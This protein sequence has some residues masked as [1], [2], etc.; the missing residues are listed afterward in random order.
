[1]KL[2]EV[3]LLDYRRYFVE[4][5]GFDDAA[6]KVVKYIEFAPFNGILNEDGDLINEEG[7]EIEVLEVRVVSDF[8]IR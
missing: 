4:A 1:M 5:K 8:M 6:D 2:Y 3:I 7:K